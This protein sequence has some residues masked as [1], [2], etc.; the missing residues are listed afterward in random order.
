MLVGCAGQSIS[1]PKEATSLHQLDWGESLA[2]VAAL[3][4]A[5]TPCISKQHDQA[6]SQSRSVG[7][8][9]S[10]RP[11]L[12]IVH[13]RSHAP[14]RPAAPQQ[15]PPPRREQLGRPPRL[16]PLGQPAQPRTL[17]RRPWRE[18]GTFTCFARRRSRRSLTVLIL[19]S[20]CRLYRHDRFSTIRL[21]PTVASASTLVCLAPSSVPL[22]S[23][24]RRVASAISCL[25]TTKRRHSTKGGGSKERTASLM[26]RRVWPSL[27]L[28]GE[29]SWSE[30]LTLAPFRCSTSSTSATT[31]LRLVVT[32]IRSTSSAS[33][34]DKTMR[35]SLLLRP[36]SREPRN[37]LLP[38]GHEEPT[39]RDWSKRRR[40]G[41]GG[42]E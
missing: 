8:C 22:R 40:L 1:V 4:G 27:P 6:E 38:R 35:R 5:L 18:Q 28:V 42:R 19:S 15:A 41:R 13:Y 20:P 29:R 37:R 32:C 7:N 39:F 34:M 14:R 3:Y 23:P 10:C 17:W 36:M 25:R 30:S 12:A 31:R 24:T 33:R 26:E 21:D 16:S 9:F 11:H 2:V